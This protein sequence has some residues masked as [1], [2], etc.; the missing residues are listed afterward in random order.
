MRQ[1]LIIGAGITGLAA[2]YELAKKGSKVIILEKENEIGGLA[3]SFKYDDFIF[4]AGPHR[5]FTDKE[6]A[7][8]FIQEVIGDNS[9]LLPHDSSV[10]FKGKYYGWPL[11]SSLL[12]N[13]PLSIQINAFRDLFFK[14]NTVKDSARTFK[15]YIINNYGLTLHNCFFKDY[16]QK[17]FGLSSD[18]LDVDWARSGMEKAIIDKRLPHKDLFKIF[19]L[20]FLPKP[21]YPKFLYPKGGMAAFCARLAEN[22][23]AAGGRIV[24]GASVREIST[25][26]GEVTAITTDKEIFDC[27]NVIWTAP[28]GL[29]C[30]LLN[31][32]SAGLKY[33]SL[34]LYNIILKGKIKK[35]F[36]WIYFGEKEI[37][38]NRISIP[39]SFDP[40]LT[41]G[42]KT[43]LC[44]EV[45]CQE[46]NDIW[47][48]PEKLVEKIKENLKQ[49]G[50]LNEDTAVESIF[51]ERVPNAYPVY[52]LGYRD[53]L[54]LIQKNLLKF[55][56]LK[57][58][59]R[60]GA[61]LYNNMDECIIQ[62]INTVLGDFKA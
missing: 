59:G 23:R 11:R 53:K 55:K 61:F 37:V 17:F 54:N 48:F 22:I 33:L 31:L 45:T 29:I 40:A 58:I 35:N 2:G 50:F 15:D 49:I 34:V 5:F 38:F 13:L 20:A 42:D 62:G 10:Y 44:V 52:E 3:K 47:E 26:S 57:V 7:L 21:N 25:G 6:L 14:R 60:T 51:I 9:I 43:G 46:G 4:D 16:T 56:N 12:F 41:F 24:T 18:C 8:K 28:N 32:P 1:N 27:K 19:K 36:Q 39:S 30:K